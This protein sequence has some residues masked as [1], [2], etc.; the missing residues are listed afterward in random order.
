[1][2]KFM[3][4]L[5]AED[6]LKWVTEKLEEQGG[7]LYGFSEPPINDKYILEYTGN[8]IGVFPIITVRPTVESEI[9]FIAIVKLTHDNLQIDLKSSVEEKA[10]FNEDRGKGGN[11][12]YQIVLVQVDNNLDFLYKINFPGLP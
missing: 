4:Y 9:A 10:F 12:T 1:M 7:K 5:Q 6:H 8:S 11:K 2:K 3:K